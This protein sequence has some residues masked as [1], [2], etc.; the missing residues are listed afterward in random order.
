MAAWDHLVDLCRLPHRGSTTRLE[1]EAARRLADR[2]RETGADVRVEPFSAPRDTLYRGPAL[3]TIAAGL[4][5]TLA[6]SHP[7]W[8][9]AVQI[10][11]LAILVGELLGSLAVDFDL[12]LPRSPSQNI[13]AVWPGDP[14]LERSPLVLMA[15]YDTQKASWLFHPRL[16]PWLPAIFGLAYA[17]LGGATAALG[18]HALSPAAGWPAPVARVCAVVLLVFAALLAWGGWRGVDVPGANDNGS[19]VALALALAERWRDDPPSAR[20][21]WVVLTGAEEVGER[22]AKAFLRHHATALDP[23]E[24]LIVN[25]DNIGGGQLRFLTG[26]GLLRYYPYDAH[27]L[28]AARVLSMHRAP[29]RVGPWRNLVLPTDAL[30]FAARGFRVI[31]FVGIGRGGAI[32]NYHWPTDTLGRVDLHLLAFA[33]EFLWEYL[34][35]VVNPPRAAARAGG[36]R[37]SAR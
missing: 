1:A 27:L 32:P 36:P 6:W 35:V 2:L 19:G 5:C 13:V 20:P 34:R 16:V 12:I 15:H 7:W 25:L 23:R 33:E 22:G 28:S 24:T 21:L 31:T 10:V 14:S 4:A 18:A 3:V 30:P 29:D 37:S 26:E 9:L 17:A 11:F 8:G